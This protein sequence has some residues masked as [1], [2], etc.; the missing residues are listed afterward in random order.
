MKKVVVLFVLMIVALG[1]VLATDSD[2]LVI[3]LNITP[4]KPEFVMVGSFSSDSFD[5]E[6]YTASQNGTTLAYT[7]NPDTEDVTVYVQL[8]QSI[9]SKY[10]CEAGFD[11]TITASNFLDSDDKATSA[12]ATAAIYSTADAVDHRTVTP[13]A[14]SNIATY[15]FTYDGYSVAAGV[16]GVSSFTWNTTEA[17]LPYAKDG[18]HATITLGYE[19]P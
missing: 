4:T 7:G 12:A 18:Y 10:T 2:T 14:R 1:A 16:I 15:R 8:S 5:S 17:D 6:H 13:S 19:A 3:T 11:L 9:I